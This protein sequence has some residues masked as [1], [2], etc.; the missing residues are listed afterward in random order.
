MH[1]NISQWK[2]LITFTELLCPLN[3]KMH[4]AGAFYNI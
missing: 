1:K 4:V 3:D 2:R